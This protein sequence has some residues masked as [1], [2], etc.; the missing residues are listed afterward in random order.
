MTD[1]VFEEIKDLLTEQRNPNTLDI[2][3][4]SIE[5]IL[6]IINREDRIV[7][8]VVGKEIPHIKKAVEVFVETVRKGG[9]V[10]YIGAGTSGRLGVLDAAELP[11]TFGT[12]HW[13]VQGLIAG[14]YGALVRAVEG[15]EDLYED[16]ERDLRE[17][18]LSKR[19]FVIGIAASKRTPYVKGALSYARK[20]G[21][22]TALI[23]AIPR[24]NVEPIADIL[25]CPAVGPEVIMGSTR[26][27]AGTAQKL[28]L[29]MISTT[30]MI[31]LGKVYGNMMVDLM[32]TSK[33]LEERSKR[34][35][36]MVTGVD[37]ETAQT[38]LREAKGSVKTAIVMIK[39]GL[40][41]REASKR[42]K[43]V[44]GFVKRAIDKIGG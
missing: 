20:I 35:I 18:G 14:G 21:A 10:F 36:M 38:K 11:P 43:E 30:A 24:E 41:Y 39:T 1:P 12:P 2:D 31:M 29:N 34:V 7:P 27:K 33:K 28:V 15:A 22:K 6:H 5:E 13:L 3:E 44:D 23:T 17:R 8:E 16:G 4:K 26:M 32:A 40:S 25:I 9:R 19:D 42:L 37:Y